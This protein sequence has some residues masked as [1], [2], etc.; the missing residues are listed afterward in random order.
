MIPIITYIFI[1]FVSCSIE[2]QIR[3]W[4]NI[5]EYTIQNWF[6]V[7]SLTKTLENINIDTFFV[8][9]IK[10]LQC[11]ELWKKHVQ[12]R[13]NFWSRVGHV[14]ST[15]STVFSDSERS[16]D[17]HKVYLIKHF[18]DLLNYCCLNVHVPGKGYFDCLSCD[19]I[20]GL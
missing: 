3:H 13:W 5:L 7:L 14:G 12:K 9:L 8:L 4:W 2:C 17:F 10:D 1:I 18:L 15:Y 19:V 16:E 20:S 11:T 6:V